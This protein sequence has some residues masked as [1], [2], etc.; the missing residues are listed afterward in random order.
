[1]TDMP[2]DTLK[3]LIVAADRRAGPPPKLAS[4]LLDRALARADRRRFPWPVAWAAAAA[5]VLVVTGYGF[6]SAWMKAPAPHSTP[7]VAQPTT[8]DAEIARLRR[9]IE[10]LR[11][12]A[13]ARERVF[14]QFL[15]EDRQNRREPAVRPVL[16]EDDPLAV[17]AL[18]LERA[19]RTIVH[20]ADR[21]ARE[22]QRPDE[23]R[24]LYQ[25]AIELFP[26]TSAAREAAKRRDALGPSTGE[27]RL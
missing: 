22:H 6:V 12:E 17:V 20:Q 2:N 1:M 4:N 13:D 15:R 11:A 25:R 9:E 16:A 18:A 14:A 19:A 5:I 10:E 21:L 8:D 26:N 3:S 23:A 27:F 7:L 24:R